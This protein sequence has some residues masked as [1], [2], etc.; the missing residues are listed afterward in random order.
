MKIIFDF[1]GTLYDLID[2]FRKAFIEVF[3]YEHEHMNELVQL[4]RSY[5]DAVFD[6]ISSGEMSMEDAYIY[7]IQKALADYDVFIS[8]EKAQ[9]FQDSYAAFQ[10]KIEMSSTICGLLAL[11]NDAH[12]TC[13]VITNG[14]SDHQWTKL[15]AVGVTKYIPRDHIIVSGDVPVQKPNPEIFRLMEQKL[16]GEPSD[17][18]YVGDSIPVDIAAAKSAGWK[19]VWIDRRGLKPTFEKIWDDVVSTE[20]ELCGVLQNYI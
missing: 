10:K 17:F 3:G 16:G 20:E 4:H 11:L 6:Q 5:N 13:G 2:P 19:A 1:D 9:E 8:E 12:V 7:R 18:V 14:E 15:D